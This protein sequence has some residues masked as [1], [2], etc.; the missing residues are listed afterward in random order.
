MIESVPWTEFLARWRWRQGEHITLVG[1][2]G[3]GKTTL[4]LLLM[5]DAPRSLRYQVIFACKPRDPTLSGLRKHGYRIVRDWAPIPELHPRVILWP[6]VEK[7]EDHIGQRETFK[8][9]LG[10]IYRDQGWLVF[11]DEVRYFTEHLKLR[12]P[13]ELLWQQ[14]RSLGITVVAGTQRPTHIPLLAFDQ[15]THLFL[16]RDND[17][18][19][20]RRM[21]GLG[22]ANAKEVRTTVANLAH[23][24]VL[25]VNT[26]TGVSLRTLPKL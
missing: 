9:A 23:H 13:V 15:A 22:F 16:W 14:A 24:E 7:L 19:N 26:R 21:S 3:C 12:Q 20:L 11:F 25:Y 4:S 5:R 10:G 18:T 1:P 17:E 2:T 6:K 8:S